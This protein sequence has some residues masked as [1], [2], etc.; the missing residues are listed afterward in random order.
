MGLEVYCDANGLGLLWRQLRPW[1]EAFAGDPCW[2]LIRRNIDR[3]CQRDDVDPV[4]W[5]EFLR[6]IA[7]KYTSLSERD[8]LKFDPVGVINTVVNPDPSRTY[9]FLH[10]RHLPAP[11]TRLC[12]YRCL[13]KLL[14]NIDEL[15]YSNV[16][17]LRLERLAISINGHPN[18]T[19]LLEGTLGNPGFAV[20]CTD[21]SLMPENSAEVIRNRLGLKHVQH[22]W[23][24]EIAYPYS[25]LS[26]QGHSLQAP[27]VLDASAHE[28]DDWIF[29]KRRE[30]G[31]PDWGRTVDITTAGG[32]RGV[33]EAVH[34]AIEIGAGRVSGFRILAPL[35]GTKGMDCREMRA[36]PDL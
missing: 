2:G 24:A 13:S 3:E 4:V 30:S 19:S 26:N 9:F 31:G 35:G 27:T 23:L 25:L 17:P 28:A 7:M 36:N 22:G 18:P 29:N 1:Y 32:A 6:A 14:R 34:G 8:A 20:W 11:L 21:E 5:Q 33:P 10:G 16:I 12:H 15:F